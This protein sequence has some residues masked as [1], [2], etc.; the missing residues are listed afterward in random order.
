[1]LCTTKY[2]TPSILYTDRSRVLLP[3]RSLRRGSLST[4][5]VAEEELKHSGAC[6]YLTLIGMLD[7]GHE[8][9]HLSLHLQRGRRKGHRG[10]CHRLITLE[11]ARA[12]SWCTRV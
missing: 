5:P 3:L 11:S 9:L 12:N 2:K 4:S 10:V 6:V 8:R 1:M 7:T